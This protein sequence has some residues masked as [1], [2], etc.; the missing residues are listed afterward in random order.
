MTGLLTLLKMLMGFV[1][2]KVVA[3]YTGPSGLA[4]LGQVQGVVGVLNGISSAPAGSGVVRFTSEKQAAGYD[5]CAPWWKASLQWVMILAGLTIPTAFLMSEYL[6]DLLFQDI[7][8]SWVITVTACLLPLSAIGT[9]LNSVINGQQNYRRYVLLGIFSVVVSAAL[10]LGM[11]L[12]SNIHGALLAAASQSALVGILMILAN[13]RQPWFKLRYWWRNTNIAAH[14]SIGSYTLMALT[15]AL[16]VPV[17][18]IFVRDILVENVGWAAAGQWQAVWKVSEVYLSVITIALGTYYLP[19]LASLADVNSIV[20]EIHHT[21]KIVFPIVCVM[22]LAVYLC[23]DIAISLLFTEEFR[24][25]R[26]LFA[27]QLIGDVIKILAWLYAYPMLSRGATKWFISAEMF[28][29]LSFVLLAYIFVD[30]YGLLGA[31]IA[32]LTNYSF[33]FL[34]VFINVKKFSR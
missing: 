19:K 15:T 31:N 26:D 21:A 6:A 25:A 11:I 5:E 28:F 17:S 8:L 13:F 16:T 27:V 33:Y 12:Y 29:S 4:M 34:F 10:M 1:I 18:L 24:A 20:K 14:K 9:L 2:A 22:A 3:I 30:A 32:Y 7:R 23:R